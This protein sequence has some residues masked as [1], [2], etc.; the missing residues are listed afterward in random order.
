[1][2]EALYKRLR[3]QGYLGK[4]GQHVCVDQPFADCFSFL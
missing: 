4:Q 2:S 3:K 1:M